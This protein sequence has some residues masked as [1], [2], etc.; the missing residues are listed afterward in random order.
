MKI[1]MTNMQPGEERKKKPEDPKSWKNKQDPF[2]QISG[3][4]PEKR[5]FLRKHR[6]DG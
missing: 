4:D 6:I 5:A 3:Q 2:E 1:Y